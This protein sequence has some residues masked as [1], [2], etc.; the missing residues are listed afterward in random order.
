MKFKN[1][2]RSPSLLPEYRAGKFVYAVDVGDFDAF[3]RFGQ[4]LAQVA[5]NDYPAE[6]EACGLADALLAA[7]GGIGVLFRGK[8]NN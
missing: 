4:A 5:R 2:L 1:R 7:R 6:P 8:V 3:G